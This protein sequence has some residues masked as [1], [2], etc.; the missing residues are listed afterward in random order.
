[1]FVAPDAAL[2][3]ALASFALAASTGDICAAVGAVALA[4]IAVAAH[5]DLGLTSCAQEESA[6][7]I[8]QDTSGIT[9]VMAGL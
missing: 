3:V 8:V 4:T 5:Q 1:V 9:P 2:L 6:G 7:L